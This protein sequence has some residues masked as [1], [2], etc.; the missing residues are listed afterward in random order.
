MRILGR[1]LSR[2]LGLCPDRA[3]P[4]NGL[5][6]R[7]LRAHGFTLIELMVAVAIVAILSAIAAP[8]FNGVLVRSNIR[9]LSVDLGSD[10]SFARSEAIRLG[11]AVS[12]CP[13]ANA[14]GSSCA[15]GNDWKDGWVVFRENGATLNG[16]IDAGETILRQHGA[17]PNASYSIL[18]TGGSGAL[19]FVGGGSTRTGASYTLTVAHP[20]GQSRRLVVSVIGRLTTTTVN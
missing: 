18:R 1:P 16:A 15:T 12:L 8:N 14:E 7:R 5:P 2:R 3:V 19:T 13:A 6:S 4:G 20:Q 9:S 11:S 17:L 10:I